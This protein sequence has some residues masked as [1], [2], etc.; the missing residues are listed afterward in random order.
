MAFLRGCYRQILRPRG[1]FAKFANGF[2]RHA[3]ALI[4]LN[5]HRSRQ[6]SKSYLERSNA[7]GPISHVGFRSIGYPTADCRTPPQEV[8][9]S[10]AF[11][12]QYVGASCPIAKPGIHKG[13]R[14]AAGRPYR[15]PNKRASESP[16][17]L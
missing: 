3:E 7:S 2:C 17:S 12:S 9:L 14:V 8:G 1:H 4:Y 15:L 16:R 6:A 11:S 13:F 10:L 5:A